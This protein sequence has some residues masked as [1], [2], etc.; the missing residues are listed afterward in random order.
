MVM[1]TLFH[2]NR[3]VS[4]AL[5]SRKT[6]LVNVP[7]MAAKTK[8]VTSW[9]AKPAI[10]TSTPIF[11]VLPCQLLEDAIPEPDA[12]TRKDRMSQI[13]KIFVIFRQGSPKMVCESGGR[14]AAIKRPIVT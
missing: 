10:R 3:A 13:T 9:V 4:F 11:S 6:I 5:P 8:T 2:P 14:T 1:C 7:R 12:W